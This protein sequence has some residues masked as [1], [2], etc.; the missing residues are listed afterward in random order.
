MD[1]VANVTHTHRFDEAHALN[2]DDTDNAIS[3]RD[4]ECVCVRYTFSPLEINELMTLWQQVFFPMCLGN[5]EIVSILFCL[6]II[7]LVLL[8]PHKIT[9]IKYP[10]ISYAIYV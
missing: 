7:W 10:F 6:E 1:V 5:V 9:T 2:Y 4:A 8:K 3:A